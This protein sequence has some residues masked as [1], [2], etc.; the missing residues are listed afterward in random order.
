[1]PILKQLVS[2]FTDTHGIHA[3]IVKPMMVF[4]PFHESK[5]CSIAVFIVNSLH[6]SRN[7]NAT[8]T[9]CQSTLSNL[10]HSNSYGFWIC[11][12]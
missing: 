2:N 3:S 5:I 12:G 7:L 9:L 11:K 6:I 8:F 4:Y 10:W 1:M